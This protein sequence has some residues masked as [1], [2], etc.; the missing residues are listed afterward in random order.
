MQTALEFSLNPLSPCLQG[1][2][3]SEEAI[4]SLTY[5][6]YVHSVRSFQFLKSVVSTHLSPTMEDA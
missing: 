4:P 2:G 6:I 5:S 3:L 1:K